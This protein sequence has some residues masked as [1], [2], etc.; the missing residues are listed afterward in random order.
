MEW[1]VPDSRTKPVLSGS[2]LREAI[3]SF[4]VPDGC[5][6]TWWLTQASW[7]AKFPNDLLVLIDPWWRDLD[8]GDRWGK[9][10]GE[11]PLTPEEHPEPDV[12]L[13]THW[14]DDHICPVSLPRFAATFKDV[15]F[16]VPNRS[17]GMLVEMGIDEER[18]IGM[19]GDDMIE[20]EDPDLGHA[21][22]AIPAAHE[23]LDVDEDGFLY[24][25]YMIESAGVTLFHMG[26]SRPHPEWQGMVHQTAM[27]LTGRVDLALLCIN[28][29]D[30]LRHDEAVDLV[31]FLGDSLGA[32]MPMHYGMDPGN[33][34]DPD[35]FVQE[36]DSRG[37]LTPH[38]VPKVGEAITIG[39]D[40]FH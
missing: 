4:V 21:I 27:E 20:D 11:F 18:L 24:L 38:R 17:L 8:A 33:T 5:V 19:W 2:A 23:D 37:I 22:A 34:V 28:G 12:I 26:D 3:E 31:D 25:G 32:V 9:L 30:N 14:H 7:I 40:G 36:M 16:V 10:L 15:P 6:T 29:N 39:R 13:C 1:P 35:I